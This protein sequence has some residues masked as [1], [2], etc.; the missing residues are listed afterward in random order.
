[1]GEIKKPMPAT[2]SPKAV[3]AFMLGGHA[4]MTFTSI[5]SGESFT[6]KIVKVDDNTPHFSV[7][8]LRGANNDSD[9]SYIGRIYPKSDDTFWPA[10]KYKNAE[11]VYELPLSVATYK[12]IA[13]H[14]HFVKSMEKMHVNHEGYCC[15]CGRMLT[16]LKSVTIGIG[17]VCLDLI[18]K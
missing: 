16:T 12:W 4:I 14:A 3:K 5:A 9:Y 17:P 1:M 15:R 8:I 10:N 2:L 13:E 6:Y 7:F 18:N 11:G